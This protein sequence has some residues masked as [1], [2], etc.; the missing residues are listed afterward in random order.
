MASYT[1]PTELLPIFDNSV[2]IHDTGTG[3]TQTQADALYLKK[4]V[5]DTATALETFSAGI[6]TNDINPI[7]TTGR[8]TIGTVNGADQISPFLPAIT[9]G[10][11]G[12]TTRI[13]NTVTSGK[14]QVN[15]IDTISLAQSMVIGS[16][17]ADNVTICNN[18][19]VNSF[20]FKVST[21][22]LYNNG[23]QSMITINDVAYPLYIAPSTTIDPDA[24]CSALILGNT[25]I[26]VTIEGSSVTITGPVNIAKNTAGTN[27][28]YIE[29]ISSTS[30]NTINFH[31]NSNYIRNYDSRIIASGGTATDG[32][33]DLS[34]TCN[35]LNITSTS[36]TNSGTL[37][38]TGLIT[39]NGGLTMGAGKNIS[40][41]TATFVT[42]TA[43]TQLGGKYSA[44]ASITTILQ[45][46]SAVPTTVIFKQIT[47]AGVYIF[48]SYSQVTNTST[49]TFFYSNIIESATLPVVNT[50]S[51]GTTLVPGGAN[52]PYASVGN[53][54]GSN[55][56]ASNGS[57]IVTVPST[58]VNYYYMMSVWISTGGTL[59]TF[60]AGLDI[61]RIA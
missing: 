7:S 28:T 37:S 39:A 33:G 31:S 57:L 41:Q 3:L 6:R 60:G 48:N 13:G 1:P 53:V 35:T 44:T 2:F 56:Y 20:Y 16:T 5:A 42:P 50:A 8:M 34:I 38:S 11:G 4:T 51:S 12:Q 17:N 21:L 22:I 27:P 14:L 26:P 19:F 18:L 45:N 23:T 61:T 9:V 47:E 46:A 49:F 30:T 15:N 43:F 40:L 52:Y 55:Y 59:G 32:N 24:L 10:K 58:K 36:T 29:T 25:A 54:G